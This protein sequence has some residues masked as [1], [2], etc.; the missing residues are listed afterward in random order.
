[1]NLLF[2][3]AVLVLPLVVWLIVGARLDER[4]AA[5]D[6]QGD[7]HVPWHK[8][9]LRVLVAVVVGIN[10]FP[11][12][13][14]AA[15]GF[16]WP[17]WAGV[18]MF[19]GILMWQATVLGGL[20]W[21]FTRAARR[22]LRSESSP[23]SEPI[24]LEGRRLRLA[25]GFWLMVFIVGVATSLAYLAGLWTEANRV[26][27][28][29]DNGIGVD[30][31]YAMQPRMAVALGGSRAVPGWYPWLIVL[32]QGTILALAFGL[33]WFIFKRSSRHWMALFTSLLVAVTPFAL[34]GDG[35]TLRF[36]SVAGV[37][38]VAAALG[39][40][41][42][43]LGIVMLAAL[44]FVF[45]DGRFRGTFAKLA[46]SVALAA[47]VLFTLVAAELVHEDWGWFLG[48]LA[49]FAVIGSAVAVQIF[50]FAEA[51]TEDRRIARALFVS[52]IL[53][54]LWLVPGQALYTAFD[55]DGWGTFIWQQAYLTL[56]L[57]TPVALGLGILYLV[58]RQGWWDMKLFVSR[59]AVVGAL[60][61]ILA[62]GY[63]FIVLAITAGSEAVFGEQS[64]A[65]AILAAT[66][67][68]ALA[69]P[70][71]RSGFQDW[72]D[73]RWFASRHVADEALETFA[74][75]IRDEIDEIRL[76][77]RLHQVVETTFGPES[78]GLWLVEPREAE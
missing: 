25:R 44:F 14:M 73:R 34:F 46:L 58:R 66:A 28:V 33:A 32:R 51:R 36:E 74:D 65:V 12:A 77:D 10:L 56:Y 23:G 67:A 27:F 62:L 68:V 78:V 13:I 40:A 76:R 35:S 53:L 2:A 6:Q 18:P 5:A 52:L 19:F 55:G 45:P 71:L 48:L 3:T 60:V 17:D 41:V 29:T 42:A 64:Q 61:P 21:L 70:R 59:T 49:A 16:A 54:G 26:V 15:Y 37:G 9:Q 75:E 38:A 47:L 69:Y 11:V 7:T 8:R 20:G 4:R 1:M 22:E 63:V 72:V 31:F 43:V 50:R 57:F 39:D 30:D 24:L